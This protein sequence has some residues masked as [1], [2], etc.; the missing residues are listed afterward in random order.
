MMDGEVL[1]TQRVCVGWLSYHAMDK[2]GIDI[3]KAVGNI[4]S[5]R[6]GKWFGNGR[7]R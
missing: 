4:F 7:V 3:E 6:G 2:G 5:K 1:L